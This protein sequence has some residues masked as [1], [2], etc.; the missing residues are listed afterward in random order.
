MNPDRLSEI[1][2]RFKSLRVL[3]VGDVILDRYVFGKVERISPEAPVP[4]VEVQREEFRLGGAGNVAH[5]LASL[6]VKTYL[7]GVVG[8]DFGRHIIRGL[9]KDS[10]IEDLLVEDP[11]RPTTEK[12]RIV[13]L[14]QQLLRI[15]SESRRSLEG[16]ALEELLQRI[17][18]DVD[19][20]VVSDYAKGVV[21]RSTVDRI[22]ERRVFFSVDPRPQNRELYVGADLMTPNEKEAM[23][24]F[25]EDSLQR[26]GW[27]LKGKLRL[28]TLVITLGARGMALFDREFKVFPARAKQV[29]DVSGAGDTVVAVLTACAL[30]GLDWDTACELANLCAGIVVGKLGT[31]VVRPEEIFQSLEEGCRI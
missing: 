20:I 16:K 28:K 6:G 22:R 27:G 31:A 5:N 12:T 15:D 10:G 1:L 9:L 18:L 23:A 19:G 11:S 4:V 25:S 30:A 2:E 21:C 7:L 17:D 24:M 3:V 26:L 13:A 29:Y 14:S 8:Q